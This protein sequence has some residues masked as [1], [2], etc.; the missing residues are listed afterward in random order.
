M[1]IFR[2][3]ELAEWSARSCPDGGNHDGV[4]HVLS[5]ALLVQ[6]YIVT[7]VFLLDYYDLIIT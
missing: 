5:L 4:A 2:N 7:C 3:G 1:L 6:S